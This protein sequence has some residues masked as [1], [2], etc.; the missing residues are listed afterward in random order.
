MK[1]WLKRIVRK[2]VLIFFWNRS[3]QPLT[4]KDTVSGFEEAVQMAREILEQ[5]SQQAAREL[6]LPVPKIRREDNLTGC[7][8]V[9]VWFDGE[10]TNDCQISRL[11]QTSLSA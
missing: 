7:R 5:S 4:Q 11:D 1:K 2:A 9:V 3:R 8:L 6:R 10:E